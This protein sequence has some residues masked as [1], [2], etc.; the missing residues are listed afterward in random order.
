MEPKTRLCF[1]FEYQNPLCKH[2]IP[3]HY[4]FTTHLQDQSSLAALLEKNNELNGRFDGIAEAEKLY[5]SFH[6][7]PTTLFSILEFAERVQV[8]SCR[9]C[10]AGSA[11]KN[12]LQLLSSNVRSS[13]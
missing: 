1:R 11:G 4:P 2:R 8:S 13:N 10:A 9:A 12:A 7:G 3:S 5:E 6:F